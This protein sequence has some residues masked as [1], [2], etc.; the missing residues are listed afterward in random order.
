MSANGQS[1]TVTYCVDMTQVTY[2]DAQGKDVTEPT[3]KARIPAKNT[4]V[5]GSNG[6]W[7]APRRKKPESR[8]PARSAEWAA[9]RTC[10]GR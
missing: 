10:P 9:R 7:L 6:H 8:T 3:N 5:P 4:M 1:A 2:V